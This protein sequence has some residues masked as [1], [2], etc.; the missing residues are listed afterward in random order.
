MPKG[1]AYT[2]FGNAKHGNMTLKNP[3]DETTRSP[4]RLFEIELH[5]RKSQK[6]SII[7]I[8]VK[9]SQRTVFGYKLYPSTERLI[10]SDSMVTAVESCQP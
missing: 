6:A 8:A 10:N 9:T 7:E 1:K 3:E 2:G 4:K 5:G